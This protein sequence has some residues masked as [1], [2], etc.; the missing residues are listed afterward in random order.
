MIGIPKPM[1]YLKKTSFKC[2]IIEKKWLRPAV[3]S[4]IHSMFLL[5]EKTNELTKNWGCQVLFFFFLTWTPFLL[6]TIIQGKNIVLEAQMLSNGFW[7]RLCFSPVYFAN[8]G[9]AVR[10]PILSFCPSNLV[11]CTCHFLAGIIVHWS[12][13][14]V[15][16]HCGYRGDI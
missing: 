11:L 16:A 10:C 12:E 4:D 8:A 13:W 14:T 2:N 6:L 7:G 3:G 1:L 5:T 9:W 15:S